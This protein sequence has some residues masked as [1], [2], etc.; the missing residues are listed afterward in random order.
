FAEIEAWAVEQQKDSISAARAL[1]I[2]KAETPATDAALAEI[3]NEALIQYANKTGF[4][5]QHGSVHAHFGSGN[6]MVGSVTFKDGSAGINFAPVREKLG[7]I[8]TD[9]EWTRGKSTDDVGSVF[10][11]SSTNAAG[12]VVIRNKLDEAIDQLRKEQGK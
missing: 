6:V 1:E 3:R 10:V 5:F 12:L 8:G 2:I 11:I 4:S 9:Y 7:G